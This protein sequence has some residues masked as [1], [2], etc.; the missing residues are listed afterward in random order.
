MF[1]GNI[2][3]KLQFAFPDKLLIKFLISNLFYNIITNHTEFVT[4]SLDYIK[5]LTFVQA[6]GS[7]IIISNKILIYLEQTHHDYIDIG[8]LYS[9]FN[10]PYVS[11]VILFQILGCLSVNYVICGPQILVS[12]LKSFEPLF[13]VYLSGQHMYLLPMLLCV[14]G[15]LIVLSDFETKFHQNVIIAIAVFISNIS[16][17]LRNIFYK[18][19]CKSS[20]SYNNSLPFLNQSDVILLIS[21]VFHILFLTIN[22]LSHGIKVLDM[23]Y[24]FNLCLNMVLSSYFYYKFHYYSFELLENNTVLF[25]PLLKLMQKWFMFVLQFLFSD[26]QLVEHNNILLGSFLVFT[27]SFSYIFTHT[28]T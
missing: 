8:Q 11:F 24:N 15:I 3:T 7:I 28:N 21:N 4:I 1:Y 19:M 16:F 20:Q 14:G 9:F 22:E 13:S 2:S 17:A 18:K 26:I 12:L 25:L 5:L 10:Q 6:F 27:G 23:S